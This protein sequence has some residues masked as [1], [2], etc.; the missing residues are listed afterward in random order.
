MIFDEHL[1]FHSHVDHIID[2]T[3]HAHLGL[4]KR[5]KAGVRSHPRVLFY[6]AR[7]LSVLSYAAPCWFSHTSQNDK[8]KLKRFQKLYTR[9]MIPFEEENEERLSLLKPEELNIY[10]LILFV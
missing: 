6:K 1:K 5:I 2:K 7:I 10:I 3:K 9:I 4:I 8:L